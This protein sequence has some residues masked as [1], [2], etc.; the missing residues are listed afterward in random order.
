M[1]GRCVAGF[2]VGALSLLVPMYQAE[3]APR[4]IRGA[5]ISTYQLMITLGIFLAAVF[6]YVAECHLSS[7]TAPWQIT[8][9]LS[10]IFAV[11][12]GVGILFFSETPR[13][14]YRRGRICEAKSTMMR[15]YGVGGDHYS[16]HLELEE[17]KFKH[18][19]E[20]RKR[21]AVEEWF[22]M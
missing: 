7:K 19:A 8:M 6:N 9:A 10:F 22:G 11:I 13:F 12:L 15:V 5:L 21:N 17:I 16:I 14:D 1:V 2:G 18:E 4:H 3:T 20:S